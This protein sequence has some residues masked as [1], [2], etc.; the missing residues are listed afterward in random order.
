MDF[1]AQAS[2]D[3][4]G[5]WFVT[6]DWGQISPVSAREGS[7]IFCFKCADR[8]C[9]HCRAVRN[10]QLTEAMETAQLRGALRHA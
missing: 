3:F 9:L 2:R 10:A 5:I 6:D 8:L 1:K 4:S 7:G